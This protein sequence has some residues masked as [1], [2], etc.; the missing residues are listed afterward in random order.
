VGKNVWL[1]RECVVLGWVVAF[2]W[3]LWRYKHCRTDAQLMVKVVVIVV[4]KDPRSCFQETDVFDFSSLLGVLGAKKDTKSK[5]TSSVSNQ[6]VS[7]KDTQASVFKRVNN[8]T[9]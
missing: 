9:V 1:E 8:S 4:N 2:L 6:K 7:Q 3:D 5:D